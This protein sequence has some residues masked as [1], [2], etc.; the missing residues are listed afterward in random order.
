[1][2]QS[3]FAAHHHGQQAEADRRD[4]DQGQGA[5]GDAESDE[6]IVERQVNRHGDEETKPRFLPTRHRLTVEH[7]AQR[8]G[9]EC[10]HRHT[11]EHRPGITEQTIS[12]MDQRRTIGV[13][14]EFGSMI[15]SGKSTP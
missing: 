8:T 7:H 9:D 10:C 2:V 4:I 13:E 12:Q 1:M 14:L 5:A 6:R 11:D 3:T 15:V